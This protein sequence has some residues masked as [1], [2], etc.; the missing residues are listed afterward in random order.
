MRL[1]HLGSRRCDIRKQRVTGVLGQGQHGLAP[2]LSTDIKHGSVP[3]NIGKT[4]GV[5]VPCPQSQPRQ[6]QQDCAV[7]HPRGT[8]TAG[9]DGALDIL[10]RDVPRQGA[11]PPLRHRRHGRDQSS[12]HTVLRDQ[13]AQIHAHRTSEP[14]GVMSRSVFHVLGQHP[15][16]QCRIVGPRVVAESRQER[17]DQADVAIY[18]RSTDATVA[19]Q[20]RAEPINTLGQRLLRQFRFHGC[21][22][23][24]C[25]EVHKEPPDLVPVSGLE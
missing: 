4:H 12:R 21:N 23:S 13:K 19:L 16:E 8:V 11:Q 14:F 1:V 18:A 7:A 6:K 5:D 17:C 2:R 24:G 20:P 9:R 22:A 3:V 15:T 10:G 25:D